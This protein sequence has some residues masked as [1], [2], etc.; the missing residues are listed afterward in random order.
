[1][2]KLLFFVVMIASV[3][4]ILAQ[5]PPAKTPVVFS[6]KDREFALKYLGETKDE[7][8]K[9]LAGVSDAQLNFRP[10]ANKWTAAEI[11]EHI[12][13]SEGTIL[14]LIQGQILKSPENTG[15]VFRAKDT[16]VILA[17]TNRSQKFTAPEILKPAARFKTRDELLSNFEKAR[18]QTIEFV[19]TNKANMRGHFFENPL[20]GMIDGYQ[21]LLF[22]NGHADRHLAQLK[23][24]KADPAYPAK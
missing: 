4:C 19:R 7:F 24:V 21:W 12:I 1:M 15:D 13:V 23:E 10:A 20:M 3:S 5:A 8:A 2:N 18:S 9:Q 6:E 17:I 16:G 14:G 11:A 22:L